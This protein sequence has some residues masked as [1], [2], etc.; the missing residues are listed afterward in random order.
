MVTI[1]TFKQCG[2]ADPAALHA[3]RTRPSQSSDQVSRRKFTA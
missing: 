3:L 1:N 2:L